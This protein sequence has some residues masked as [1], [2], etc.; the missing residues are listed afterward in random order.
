[1][2]GALVVGL[3]A[4]PWARRVTGFGLATL[5]IALF[6]INL[7]RQ[8]VTA[9]LQPPASGE[10]IGVVHVVTGVLCD[11]GHP[12]PATPACCSA[13]GSCR[14]PLHQAHDRCQRRQSGLPPECAA[15]PT[16]RYP[17]AA[18]KQRVQDQPPH[19]L[20]AQ[21]QRGFP[22]WTFQFLPAGKYLQERYSPLVTIHPLQARTGDPST[23]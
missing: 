18:P 5:T 10:V 19:H 17:R 15:H 11:G 3:L 22:G 2:W 14:Q 23:I 6:V 21:E 4:R 7:R 16:A 20:F 8:G 1:M 9:P 12:Q 13:P